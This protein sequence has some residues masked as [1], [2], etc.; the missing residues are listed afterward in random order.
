MKESFYNHLTNFVNYLQNIK[1]YSK[2]T[3]KTYH[4]PISKMIEVSEIY[5]END[6]TIID[7]TK[8][9]INIS[10]QNPKTINKKL[11]SIR[12]FVQ[13]LKD[14]NVKVKLTGA[15]SVKSTQTLPKPISTDN[16]F[17]SLKNRSI[18][19]KL[20]V[21]FVYSFGV[22]ISELYSLKL[23]NINS[24]F[25]TVSG[26]GNKQ[27]QIPSNETINSLVEQYK[28][29]N[30]PSVYLFEKEGKALSGRQLQYRIEKVFKAIGIKATPHQL[31]HSFATDLLNEGARINDISE[32]LGHGSLKATGIYTK[33]T[34]NTKLKQYNMSHP[35]SKE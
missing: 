4:T 24:D 25:V 16:I 3:A 7:I 28:K 29:E 26:K 10:T 17:E 11:S 20:I 8:Y 30:N 1:N 13:F 12:S 34:T 5:E 32:L 35:L 22:R 31:R 33:L 2:L 19:E 15:Q 14:K 9:R 21:L 27:R 23:E 6:L 18:E